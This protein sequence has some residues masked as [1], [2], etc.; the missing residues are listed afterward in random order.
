[1]SATQPTV[2][3]IDPKSKDFAYL[4]KAG[5][6]G[7][8]T[9]NPAEVVFYD[10]RII[11][12]GHPPEKG[13]KPGFDPECK[14]DSYAH[15]HFQVKSEQHGIVNLHEFQRTAPN[16]GSKALDW[17]RQMGVAVNDKGQ[18]KVDG[19]TP[20]SGLIIEVTDPRPDKKDKSKVYSGNVIN[21]WQ[22]K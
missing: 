12:Q 17:L 3:E 6:Y 14:D 19:L 18:F 21:V 20:R 13:R 22:K 7:P 8:G 11:P 9:P 16:T 5:K 15:F 4:P 1:M 2:L 10:F